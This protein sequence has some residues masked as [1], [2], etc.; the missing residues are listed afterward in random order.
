MIQKEIVIMTNSIE[1][2]PLANMESPLHHH[3]AHTNAQDAGVVIK[4][5]KFRGH[6]NL[7]GNPQDADFM[8]AVESVLGIA[9]PTKPNTS[10]RNA[11]SVAYWLCPNEWL[12]IVAPGTQ[13][14]VEADLREAVAK[15]NAHPHIAV[16][17]VSS[18]Q[19]LVNLSGP[20]MAELLQKC[21]VY[22]CHADNLPAGKVVQ[23][24]F[25]KTGTT[26]CKLED[27]SV[28]LVIRRSFADYFFLWVQDASKE[29]GLRIA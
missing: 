29:Y 25:A 23:T 22:D 18:G 2:A 9:L 14:Q 1:S 7:R 13:A 11:L 28:D 16:T 15:Q 21:T 19:T 24:T 10:A 8:T 26:I 20:D 3:V 4:E 6:L 12:L 27:G 17:D 5:D